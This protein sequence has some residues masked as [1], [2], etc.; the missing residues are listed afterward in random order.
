MVRSVELHLCK[1]GGGYKLE[2]GIFVRKILF[3]VVGALVVDNVE[4]WCVFMFLR[5]IKHRHPYIVDCF[6]L[7]IFEGGSVN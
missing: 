3:E 5:G 2:G 7:S 1:W 6:L 4:I